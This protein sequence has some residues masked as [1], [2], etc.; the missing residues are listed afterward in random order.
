M[1]EQSNFTEAIDYYVSVINF[2]AKELFSHFFVQG[3]QYTKLSSV[4]KEYEHDVLSA[5]MYLG[6]LITL[7]DD[8]AD[9]PRCFNPKLLKILYSLMPKTS[10]DLSENDAKILALKKYL[11]NRMMGHIE[12]LPSQNALIDI[13]DFDLEKIYLSNRFSELMTS[14]QFICNS[15]EMKLYG[16]YTMGVLAAGMIDLMGTSNLIIDEVGKC[17][18]LFI[19]GQRLSKIANNIATF[20]REQREGDITNEITYALLECNNDFDLCKL[21]LERE[22]NDGIV[23]IN[24]S[25]TYI[26]IFDVKMYSHGIKKLYDLNMSMIGII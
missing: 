5:K 21:K 9:N 19:V 2:R 24:N 22:F 18:E 7:I 13:F 17:R 3:Y 25:S 20:A 26:K 6:M 1:R 12:K 23:M 8:L 15:Y 14:K 4:G 11:F 16:S 10:E